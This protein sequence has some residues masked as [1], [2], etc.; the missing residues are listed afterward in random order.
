MKVE[1]FFMFNL[2]VTSQAQTNDRI[3]LGIDHAKQE[4]QEA[5]QDNGH[6]IVNGKD[7]IIKDTVTAIDVAESI[8]FE[9]YTKDNIIKQR[10]YE[11]H[12]I[13]NYWV[14]NGTLQKGFRGGTFLCIIDDRTGE[15]LKITH[16]K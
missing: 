4:L 7:V 14:I 8:L 2:F 10:P 12:H 6:N 3:L 15:V 1:L 5:L 16:G 11:I 9:I 13:D